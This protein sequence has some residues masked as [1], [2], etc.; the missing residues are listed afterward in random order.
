VTTLARTDRLTTS[1]VY[2]ADLRQHQWAVRGPLGAVSFTVLT[3]TNVPGLS[4]AQAYDDTGTQ[5]LGAGIDRHSPVPLWTDHDPYPTCYLLGGP[6]YG[7][8]TTLGAMQLLE[9]LPYRPDTPQAWPLIDAVLRSYY[10][11]WFE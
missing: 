6:C 1:H 4:L 11:S 3:L 8:G 10:R 7:D 5:W 9:T 2:R